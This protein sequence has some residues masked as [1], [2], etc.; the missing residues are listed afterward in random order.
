MTHESSPVSD[1]LKGREGKTQGNA[2]GS[3]DVD[4]LLALL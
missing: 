4:R 1:A 2:V 3:G